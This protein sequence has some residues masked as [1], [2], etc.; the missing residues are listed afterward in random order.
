MNK[1][2]PNGFGSFKIGLVVIV[3]KPAD[4]ILIEDGWEVLQRNR[5]STIFGFHYS[6]R[7]KG[8]DETAL[9]TLG[10]S[11]PRGIEISDYRV[12]WERSVY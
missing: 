11:M 4:K 7:R 6:S 9:F 1:P 2:E 5:L 12:D 8:D 3:Q 10:H